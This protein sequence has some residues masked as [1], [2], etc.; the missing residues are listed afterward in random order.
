MAPSAKVVVHD[1]HKHYGDI[2]AARRV[3]FEIMDGEV[4]G[5]LG[6]N[7]SGKTT[8]LECIIGLPAPDAGTIES[9][10]LARRRPARR[11]AED[12]RRAP[13]HEALEQDHPA[14]SAR[15]FGSSIAKRAAPGS[16]SS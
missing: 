6:P 1:L 11:Q 8:T 9:A 3:S 4:F 5:L 12:R 16:C 10:A 13:G 14:R 7:G 15:L 2:H